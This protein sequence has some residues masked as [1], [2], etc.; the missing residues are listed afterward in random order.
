LA[1]LSLG[2]VGA[3]IDAQALSKA[4]GVEKLSAAHLF[5]EHLYEVIFAVDVK[6]ADTQA[7]DA[8]A[9]RF[10]HV[11][12]AVDSAK[13]TISITRIGATK[14]G[15]LKIANLVHLPVSQI[16]DAYHS[17]WSENFESLA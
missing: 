10:N 3:E 9:A 6:A 1:R 15:E 5:E 14:V 16:S 8:F 2:G 12:G 4:R 11:S 7:T 13:T 17:G